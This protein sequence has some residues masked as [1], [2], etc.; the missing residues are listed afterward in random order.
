M[1]KKKS[2]ELIK[3][4]VKSFDVVK[5]GEIDVKRLDLCI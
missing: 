2:F 4:M 5:I 1:N 3:L